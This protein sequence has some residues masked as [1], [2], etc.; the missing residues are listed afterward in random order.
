MSSSVQFSTHNSQISP[1]Q[2]I[3]ESFSSVAL[4]DTL[5]TIQLGEVEHVLSELLNGILQS[6]ESSIDDINSVRLRIGY[7]LVHEATKARQVCR[8]ARNSHD[9]AFSWCVAPWLVI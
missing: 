9:C 6:D 3:T 7:V 8:D 4:N 1:I 2:K 5:T